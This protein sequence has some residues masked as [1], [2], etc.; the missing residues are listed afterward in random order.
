MNPGTTLLFAAFGAAGA[1]LAAYL[2]A[3]S[4][5]GGARRLARTLYI[6]MTLSLAAASIL[7]MAAILSDDFSFPYVADYSSRATPLLYKVSAFWGGQE[8][9]LLLWTLFQAAAGVLVLRRKDDWESPVMSFLL[10]TQILLL[11]PLLALKPFQTAPPPPDGAGLNPLL[12][13]PWMAIHPPIVFI[14]YAGFAIPFAFALAALA[15][16]EPDAW[17]PRVLPWVS[18]SILSLGLGLFIGG[19]WAYKVLGWGGYWGWDPVE[20]SSLAPWLVAAA[21]VHGLLIQRATG[22]L[23]RTNFALAGMAYVLVLYATFMTRSGVLASFSVH[24]FADRGLHTPLLVAIAVAAGLTAA[25]LLMR[26]RWLKAP[27]LSWRISLP[28]ALALGMALLLAATALLVVG[29][30]WPILSGLSGRPASPG[31]GFYNRTSLPVGIGMAA[32]LVAAPLMTWAG[33]TWRDLL[34]RIAPGLAAGILAAALPWALGV[35]PRG[36]FPVLLLLAAAVGA[37]VASLTRV[38]RQIGSSPLAT[39]AGIAHA[40]LALMFIGIVATSAFDRTEPVTLQAGRAHKVFDRE[41]T[42]RR[43]VPG[44]GDEAHFEID[45]VPASGSPYV[46]AP[47]MFRDSRRDT[48]IARPHIERGL[49]GDLYIAPVSHHPPAGPESSLTLVKNIAQPWGPSTFAFRRFESHSEDGGGLSVG[50]VVDVTQNGRTE[51]MT[52]LLR[53]SPGGAESAQIPIPMSDGPT[54]RLAGMQVESGAIRVILNDPKAAATPE[55][56]A[57]DVSTKPLVNALWLGI[58]LVSAGS[59]V[60]TAHRVREEKRTTD[61]AAARWP[62]KAHFRGVS[63]AAAPR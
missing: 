50:A 38:A 57:L 18:L 43:Y 44:P 41:L 35:T 60:A 10:I 33:S 51:A 49:L 52:L 1:S 7:L 5:A 2:L 62:A 12:I 15:R 61:A 21:L 39:G 45:V 46:A 26:W 59:A 55:S 53:M 16:R 23:K 31:P 54:A 4:G 58:L 3:W 63:R 47:I 30:S 40:G 22:A 6:G 28:A 8:G 48:I 17:I 36:G 24:S 20:N 13:D 25:L 27:D 56:L 29:T 11:V 9:T 32:L 19:F 37:L 34:R 42:L 14:G